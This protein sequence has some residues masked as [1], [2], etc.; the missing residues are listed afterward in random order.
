M[1]TKAVTDDTRISAMKELLP[2]RQLIEELPL[3]AQATNTVLQARSAIQ[4][5]L[6]GEDDRL[7]VIAGPCSIHDID[8][9]LEYAGRLLQQIEKHKQDLCIIMRVYFEK[10]RTTV[11]WKG[12][13]NDPGLQLPHQRRSAPRAQP[14]AAT[15]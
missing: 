15:G 12:L 3:T 8:A 6:R 7:L 5:I 9:A 10:P 13:I 14:A 2:P 11:G 1:N 4:K